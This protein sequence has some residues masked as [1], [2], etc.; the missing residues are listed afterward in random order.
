MKRVSRINTVILASLTLLVLVLS[1]PAS[2]REAYDRGGFFLFSR[3]FIEDIPR[4]LAGPGS[5][6]FV[7]QPLVATSL[8]IR[9]GI[10]DLRRGQPPFLFGVLFHRGLRNELLKSGFSTVMNLLIMGVLLDSV[11]RWGSLGS[12][13]GERQSAHGRRKQT[14][15]SD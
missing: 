11:F 12:A 8:G 9:S 7:L 2:L 4:R 3:S 14:H 10:N 6:C 5:F 15:E 1:A 13:G